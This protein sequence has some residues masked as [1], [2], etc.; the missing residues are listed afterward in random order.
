MT[1]YFPFLGPCMLL[2]WWGFIQRAPGDVRN[3]DNWLTL[4]E[5]FHCPELQDQEG[6]M[7][8][9]GP[10][11]HLHRGSSL[12]SLDRESLLVSLHGHAAVQP[13][14]PALLRNPCCCKKTET[15][16]APQNSYRFR[17]SCSRGSGARSGDAPP[18]HL[19]TAPRAP[20]HCPCKPNTRA[21]N[22]PYPG[23]E[24]RK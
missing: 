19:R 2:E 22:F 18:T 8:L 1:K 4:H 12:L 24:L 14:N 17:H 15:L 9:Q 5:M 23:E 13:E 3:Q 7:G 6:G 10:P 21:V 11:S 16:E 20:Y